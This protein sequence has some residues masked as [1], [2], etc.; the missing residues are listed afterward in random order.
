MR[1]TYW[2]SFHIPRGL[3]LQKSRKLL[4]IQDDHQTIGND[5]VL[6]WFLTSQYIPQCYAKMC[7]WGH[8]PAPALSHPP[9]SA[10]SPD[11]GHNSSM[12]AL[13]SWLSIY[14]V[15]SYCNSSR[16][17][18][19]AG[20]SRDRRRRA[21]S[22]ELSKQ[23]YSCLWPVNCS[24]GPAQAQTGEFL[25]RRCVTRVRSPRSSRAMHKY[26]TINAAKPPAPLPSLKSLPVIYLITSQNNCIY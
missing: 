23:P 1:I 6:L 12:R 16:R 10:L 21:A 18:M 19:T 15:T 5:T 24:C 11:Y 9:L 17:G 26:A 8:G 3:L 4:V 13:P 7:I 22:A 20:K 25:R 2:P 14:K